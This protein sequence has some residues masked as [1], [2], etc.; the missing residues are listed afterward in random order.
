MHRVVFILPLHT[1]ILGLHGK[2]QISVVLSCYQYLPKLGSV[3]EN[4]DE[5][6]KVENKNKGKGDLKENLLRV[7]KFS[8]CCEN[9]IACLRNGKLRR[10]QQRGYL[11]HTNAVTPHKTSQQAHARLVA[12]LDSCHS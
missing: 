9:G 7:K 11:F 6:S 3:I 12:T 8:K 1:Y 4:L 10:K 5:R 2:C